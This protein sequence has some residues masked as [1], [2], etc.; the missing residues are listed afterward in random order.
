MKF[1][2]ED[3]SKR[4]TDRGTNLLGA[5]LDSLKSSIEELIDSGLRFESSYT[6]CVEPDNQ[7]TSH[8]RSKSL[9]R[10]QGSDASTQNPRS[11]GYSHD[12]PELDAWNAADV[13]TYCARKSVSAQCESPD[14]P[15]FPSDAEHISPVGKRGSLRRRNSSLSETDLPATEALE[16]LPAE[17]RFPADQ[18]RPGSFQVNSELEK[19]IGKQG[20]P[21][22]KRQLGKRPSEVRN[23]RLAVM[24][25]PR[26]YGYRNRAH[27]EN[28][29]P[30]RSTRVSDRR[31]PPCSGEESEPIR[32]SRTCESDQYT[33]SGLPD[34]E[35]KYSDDEFRKLSYSKGQRNNSSSVNM[36]ISYVGLNTAEAPTSVIS[37]RESR[38]QVEQPFQTKRKFQNSPQIKTPDVPRRT[39]QTVGIESCISTRTVMFEPRS[40]RSSR[41]RDLEG[42]SLS[43]P[44]HHNVTTRVQQNSKP[45]DIW[46]KHHDLEEIKSSE[47]DKMASA[48][49]IHSDDLCL[50]V[51]PSMSSVTKTNP[52]PPSHHNPLQPRLSQSSATH[53]NALHLEHPFLFSSNS[54]FCS[55]EAILKQSRKGWNTRRSDQDMD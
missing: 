18:Q 53:E 27:E 3:S 28:Q 41:G 20:T 7:Q 17:R 8:M 32:S 29:S 33:V 36:K 30:L 31:S 21:T 43:K 12:A 1:Q 16:V 35:Q 45:S 6:V 15:N 34:A 42:H 5:N 22:A 54:V 26:P 13:G 55:K 51:P 44:V 38:G 49:S 46:W 4:R 48:Q 39:S 47:Q 14:S 40:T 24:M 9:Q 50:E 52:H 2:P 19:S 37:G 11:A 25:C 10:Y 23:R